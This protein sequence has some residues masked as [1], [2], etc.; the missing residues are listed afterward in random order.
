MTTKKFYRME[1]QEIEVRCFETQSDIDEYLEWHSRCVSPRLTAKERRAIKIGD[2]LTS[3]RWGFRD[4][5]PVYWGHMPRK[6]L[7]SRWLP[8]EET[9]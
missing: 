7:E 6:T 8:I 3:T 5:D 4:D 2:Y 9:P 1:R